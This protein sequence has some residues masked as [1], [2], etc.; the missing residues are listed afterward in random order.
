MQELIDQITEKTG[1][2]VE[3]AKEIVGV[4]TDWLK[5]KLPDDMF[6]HLGSFLAD[7]GD[8]VGD[9]AENVTDTAGDAASAVGDKAGNLWD[10]TK[11]VVADLIP[12]GDN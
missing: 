12:G 10:K 4:T 9:V 7:A 6:E 3:K 1:V 5:E 8:A 2:P 11:D